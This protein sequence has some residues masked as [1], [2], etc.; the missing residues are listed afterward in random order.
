[1]PPPTTAPGAPT[2]SIGPNTLQAF[3]A[4]ER[5][6][7]AI[8]QQLRGTANVSGQASRNIAL[9]GNSLGSSLRLFSQMN[10]AALRSGDG[11]VKLKAASEAAKAEVTRLKDEVIKLQKDTYGA[12]KSF[13]DF[14]AALEAKNLP[15]QF[16]EAD[17]KARA[18]KE[19]LATMPLKGLGKVAEAGGMVGDVLGRVSPELGG[20]VSS[21][22]RGIGTVGGLSLGLAVAAGKIA[23]EMADVK[24][25]VL[26]V[27]SHMSLVTDQT[28]NVRRALREVAFAGNLSVE[29][30]ASFV[31][32]IGAAGIKADELAHIS[33]SM[34][35]T[36][37]ALNVPLEVQ[38]RLYKQITREAGN[39]GGSLS[40]GM[41][42]TKNMIRE[43]AILGQ[44]IRNLS[45]EE[46]LEGIS[47]LVKQTSGLKFDAS[48]LPKQFML[49]YTAAGLA[50]L[51][52][53]KARGMTQDMVKSIGDAALGLQGAS[54]ESKLMAV[55]LA[56]PGT[57]LNE[58]L[59]IIQKIN[60]GLLAASG[61]KGAKLTL[62]LTLGPMAN[63]MK[64]LSESMPDLSEGALAALGAELAKSAGVAPGTDPQVIA[65]IAR[66]IAETVQGGD[67]VLRDPVKMGEI[68][69]NAQEKVLTEMKDQGQIT[70]EA[71]NEFI[72]TGTLPK[73]TDKNIE[74]NTAD[75]V[76]WTTQI[77]GWTKLIAAG[78][79]FGAK[80]TLATLGEERK[81][82]LQELGLTQF[83]LTPELEGVLDELHNEG[84]WGKGVLAS[85]GAAIKGS[86]LSPFG[87]SRV[88][89]QA[90]EEAKGDPK[91]M[92]Q[93]ITEWLE[94]YKNR[95]ARPEVPLISGSPTGE[96]VGRMSPGF[97]LVSNRR[98]RPAEVLRNG[99][100]ETVLSGVP[101]TYPWGRHAGEEIPQE[102]R[103]KIA[104]KAIEAY[105]EFA[106]VF[107]KV[108]A[109]AKDLLPIIQVESGFDPTAKAPTSTATGLMQPIEGTFEL[110]RKE[111]NLEL[112]ASPT[113][114]EAGLRTG[115]GYLAKMLESSGTLEE[116]LRKFYMGP[117]S[118]GLDSEKADAY[119]DLIDRA[120]EM[121][122]RRMEQAAKPPT[123]PPVAPRVH[124]PNA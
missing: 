99:D 39:F 1:M 75:I 40:D 96:P 7:G 23:Q 106:N 62:D 95:E 10:S 87:I 45:P 115:V 26:K 55:A 24:G 66:S 51:G 20:I 94:K 73:T 43:A 30:A 124:D 11:V 70:E 52:L 78:V 97:T 49:L 86:G 68:F 83:D 93:K 82:Q 48:T 58:T 89:A 32:Q 34:F 85:R 105:D 65:R 72:K 64:M 90:K 3:T 31:G 88:L 35:Q 103:E 118:K 27:A 50:T 101:K 84:P 9:L 14:V 38:V 18:L 122:A 67:A 46:A 29:E 110:M 28:Q 81:G 42:L 91:V 61:P 120:A 53:A 56:K 37:T 74:Q 59:E 57:S 111:L 76:N 116:G 13:D 19:A 77:A 107:K 2:L 123:P 44:E 80:E 108:G 69:K 79:G 98:Q 36:Q 121:V 60:E 15:E 102:Q 4:M 21:L 25:Q 47:K 12:G 63:L 17:R 92:V 5:A 109:T 71:Y 104:Q 114:I 54:F 22:T 33:K 112:G 117:K 41:R 8:N 119:I 16:E 6:L 100:F 113:S